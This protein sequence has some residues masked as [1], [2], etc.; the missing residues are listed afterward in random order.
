V[1]E[2]VQAT[3]DYR[4]VVGGKMASNQSV[5]NVNENPFR[6]SFRSNTSNNSSESTHNLYVSKQTL[7]DGMVDAAS[8]M[9]SSE[10]RVDSS[11]TLASVGESVPF[12]Y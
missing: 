10:T 8:S 2:Q 12:P 5:P 3:V 9:T 11:D 1:Y 6:E 7:N 4:D